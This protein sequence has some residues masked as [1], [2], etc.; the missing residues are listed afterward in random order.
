MRHSNILYD[1]VDRYPR[2]MLL[3]HRLM[4]YPEIVLSHVHKRKLLS[5]KKSQ[6]NLFGSSSHISIDESW[7]ESNCCLTR[8]NCV[9]R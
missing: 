8:Q 9:D 3:P 4:A 1:H 7:R 5:A 2:R 6:F